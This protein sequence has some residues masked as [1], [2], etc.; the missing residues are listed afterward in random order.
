M[1][2]LNTLPQRLDPGATPT[3]AG[4]IAP[5]L[6]SP[7]ATN[8]TLGLGTGGTALTL[9]NSTLAATFAG[10]VSVAGQIK[11]T[12]ANGFLAQVTSGNAGFSVLSGSKNLAWYLN[13]ADSTARLYLSDGSTN[14]DR[15]TISLTTGNVSISSSTAGSASAGALV[16]TGGLSAGNNGNASYFGGAVTANGLLSVTGSGTETSVAT[17]KVGVSALG[18]IPRVNFINATNVANGKYGDIIVTD[19]GSNGAFTFRFL[20][21]AITAVTSVFSIT[22]RQGAT[23]SFVTAP[24]TGTHTFGTTNTV[25]MTAGVL[26]TTGAATF[27]GAVT[28]GNTVNTVSPTSPNRTI[29]MV[30]N[31]VTLYLAAKTTND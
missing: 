15:I 13:D 16:V 23:S 29:T 11:T 12:S 6:T 25:T 10:T 27:A 7:A 31:G 22:G 17:A 2:L 1:H 20:D 19:A 21:D 3:F 18:G 4:L 24:G 26:A 14:A 9:A 8:L 28:I 30:V 5:S